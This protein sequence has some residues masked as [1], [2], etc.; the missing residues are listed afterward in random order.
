MEFTK[1]VYT[2]VELVEALQAKGFKRKQ[3][4]ETLGLY[5]SVF[6]T[7]MN[8]AFKKVLALD[9]QNANSKAQ[10]TAI[11]KKIS[12]ISERRVRRD[13]QKYVEQLEQLTDHSE[14]TSIQSSDFY[15]NEL[16]Q[17]SPASILNQLVGLY[18][19]YYISTTGYKVKKEPFSIKKTEETY[20][21]RKGNEKS[22]SQYQGCLYLSHSYILT[23]QLQELKT[24]MPDHFII[25][26]Q[27]PPYPKNFELMKGIS[28]SMSN[29]YSP[30]SRKIIIKKVKAYISNEEYHQLETT[31]FEPTAKDLPLIPAYLYNTNALMEY[32]PVPRPSFNEGDLE[33][34]MTIERALVV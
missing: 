30:I 7:L 16:I 8:V 28:T 11:F 14:N 1:S 31:Y 9:E 29:T 27:L 33:K 21:V 34:E 20:I 17:Q 22:I 3:I 15:V 25:H 18:D 12:N 10:I 26:F 6:S 4:A 5:P 19:F 2:F 13:I 23:M 32:T 24:I